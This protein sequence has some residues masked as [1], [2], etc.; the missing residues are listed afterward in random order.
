MFGAPMA[1]AP[2]CVDY[3]PRRLGHE[4][5]ALIM[6]WRIRDLW[7]PANLVASCVTEF[8]DTLPYLHC[9]HWDSAWGT[10]GCPS[11]YHVEDVH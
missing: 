2:A 4:E 6:Y 11:R 9:I 5:Q 8:D 3:G 10:H 1:V 7:G